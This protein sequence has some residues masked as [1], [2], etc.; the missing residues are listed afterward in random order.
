MSLSLS[1]LNKKKGKTKKKANSATA[2]RK[3]ANSLETKDKSARPWSEVI[4]DQGQRDKSKRNAR[5]PSP[6]FNIASLAD[7]QTCDQNELHVAPMFFV[8]FQ[9]LPLISNLQNAF[10]NVENLVQNS[11]ILP[12]VCLKYFFKEK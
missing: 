10:L 5:P 6:E 7:G 1:D 3:M 9:D 2:E 4:L 12:L 11:I 8:S